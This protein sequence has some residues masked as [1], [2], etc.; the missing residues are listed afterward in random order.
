MTHSINKPEFWVYF[1]D[2]SDYMVSNLGNIK[3]YHKQWKKWIIKK[4]RLDS[5][6]YY[7]IGISPPGSKKTNS[8]RVHRLVA[9]AFIPNP[10][11]LPYVNHKDNDPKNNDASNLEWC[12]PK[13]NMRYSFDVN[14][15]VSGHA[16]PVALYIN[17]KFF[18]L[19]SSVEHCSKMFST[20]KDFFEV[21]K[22]RMSCFDDYFKIELVSEIDEKF[23]LNKKIFKI[24][25]RNKIRKPVSY[26]GE[27]FNS[28]ID[29]AETIGVTP[30]Q[31]R[32]ICFGK[33]EYEGI[34]VKTI[35]MK[36]FILKANL[37]DW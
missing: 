33:K 37:I 35:S 21:S 26:K 32:W 7:T 11:N 25:L 8:V 2:R 5:K 28:S 3:S 18:S 30:S 36:D 22:G 4:P 27:V 9:Q 10:N 1:K 12:T 14:N 20:S 6:G 16:K 19:Y 15:R 29:F 31:A 23:P 24:P 34:P 13:Y 17:D